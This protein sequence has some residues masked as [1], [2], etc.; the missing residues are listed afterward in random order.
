MDRD[1]RL[2]E[3]AAVAVQLQMETGVPARMMIAQWAIES[4]W[5]AKP[6]GGFNYF[7]I[8]KRDRHAKSAES[9]TKEERSGRKR[10]ELH[11][12]ADFNSIEEAARDYVYIITEAET[13]AKAWD[14][15]LQNRNIGQLAATISRYYASDSSYTDL[16]LQIAGQKNVAQHVRNV[17]ACWT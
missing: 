16:L 8:K 4:D 5:G 9:W 17:E 15:F 10:S 6:V 3:F 7:G 14:R 12:F 13:Y 1:E 11:L 2:K